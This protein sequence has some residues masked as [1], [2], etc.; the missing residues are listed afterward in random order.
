M[1]FIRRTIE[2]LFFEC[3]ARRY[4]RFEHFGLTGEVGMLPVD[5]TSPLSFAFLPAASPEGVA[6]PT[7]PVKPKGVIL[8]CPPTLHNMMFHLPQIAW[9]VASGYHVMMFDYHGAGLSEG[10]PSIEG[11]KADACVALAAL[12]KRPE[13]EGLPLYLF[14][15]GMGACAA[16]SLAK[17]NPQRFKA[18]VLESLIASYKGWMLHR[19]GPGVGHF[20]AAMLPDTLTDPIEELK[21]LQMPLAIVVPT[22]DQK[23][24]EKE[25]DRVVKEAPHQR[26]IWRVEGKKQLGVFDY[27]GVW[28]ERFLAFCEEHR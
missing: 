8:Y 14:G 2:G 11:I 21:T 26:E 16:V 13:C 12:L 3:T 6:S 10:Q 4:W 1:S 15:Q 5:G 18:V 22:K 24:P 9:L 27:P 19:Y 28:R 7:N 25:S 17:A 20:C 23:V